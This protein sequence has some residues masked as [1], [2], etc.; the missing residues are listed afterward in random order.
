MRGFSEIRFSRMKSLDETPQGRLPW[1]TP[2]GI[3][4]EPYLIGITGGSASGKTSV[5]CRII[6]L[7]NNKST[8]LLSMDSFYK[9]LTPKQIEMAHQQNHN[10]D[11]PGAFD[12]DLIY[13]T[14]VDMKKGQRVQVPTYDFSTHSR[15]AQTQSFYGA[16]IVIF[17]GIFALYD[18][19]IR[20]VLDLKIFVDSDDDTRLARRLKR[21]IS[22]RGRDVDGVIEQYEKYVKPAYTAYIKPCSF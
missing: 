12:M 20:D 2:A 9:S 10:F 8:T 7:L 11:E 17:E 16:N 18:S 14:L 4:T 15:L 1:F 19:R 13:S 6:N 3:P 22:E 21:D 5:S